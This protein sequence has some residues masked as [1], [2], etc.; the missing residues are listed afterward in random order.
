MCVRKCQWPT[1]G[2][3]HYRGTDCTVAGASEHTIKSRMRCSAK[4]CAHLQGGPT[5][6][7]QEAT[8]VDRHHLETYAHDPINAWSCNDEVQMCGM[9]VGIHSPLV[10]LY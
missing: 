9:S 10:L 2:V 3:A 6:G 7:K 8:V 4:Y 5:T 1:T